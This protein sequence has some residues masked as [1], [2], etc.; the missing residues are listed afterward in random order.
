[1]DNDTWQNYNSASTACRKL[2]YF[3]VTDDERFC[4]H[5]ICLPD[6]VYGTGRMQC[7]NITELRRYQGNKWRRPHHQQQQVRASGQF[8]LRRTSG[9]ARLQCARLQRC[10]KC[11]V[12]SPQSTLLALKITPGKIR[13]PHTLCAGPVCIAH[14]AIGRG[15]RPAISGRVRL[16]G[17]KLEAQKGESG[18]GL[19]GMEQPVPSLPAGVSGECCMLPHGVWGGCMLPHRVC[20]VLDAPPRGLR[21]LLTGF[22]AF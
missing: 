11:S 9:V 19:L 6:Y 14:P 3:T 1:M 15:A 13:T 7:G 20:G 10:R 12:S 18:V 21:R 8:D 16:D 4:H 2:C 22:L 5:V 17:P